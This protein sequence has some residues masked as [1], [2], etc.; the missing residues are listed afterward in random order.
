LGLVVF[1]CGA[2]TMV[3]EL[4]GS[5]LL[6]PYMGTSIYVWTGL[7]GIILGCLSLGYWWGGK[8][9]DARPDAGFFSL[10]I[11]LAALFVGALAF[12]NEF[13][14]IAIQLT[15]NDLRLAAVAASLALF[16]V[17]SVLL[18]MAV[19]YAVRLKMTSVNQSGSTVGG[20]YA[21]STI[22]SIAGTFLAGFFLIAY[23]NQNLILFLVAVTLALA[24]AAIGAQRLLKLKIVV[25]AFFMLCAVA[26]NSFAAHMNSEL[27][28]LNT[29]YNRVRIYRGYIDQ[30]AVPVKIMQVNDETD[31]MMR[32]DSDD[33]AAE[34]TKYYRLVQHF[35][36]GF[37][38]TLMIGGAAYSYPKHY[39]REFPEAS[40]DVVE[41]DPGL[42]ELARKHF[43]LKDDPRLRIIHE[44]A[45]TFLNR[46]E[47][48]YD[49][50]FCD[51]FKSYSIP[52]QL[53]TKEAAQKMY[54]LLSANGVVI[55]NVISSVEGDAGM[56]LRAEVATMKS[57]FPKVLLYPV[58]D[59]DDPHLVQN[60]ML[61]ALKSSGKVPYVNADAELDKFLHHLWINDL[62]DDMPVITDD[63]APV[64]RYTMSVLPELGNRNR[65]VDFLNWQLQR[66]LTQM[67]RWLRIEKKLS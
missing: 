45:R 34:Y 46:G 20:L 35:N 28:D 48:R 42:T 4:L 1:I 11:F 66:M 8:M 38:K 6:A 36:P 29:R 37:K 60:I 39:L 57:V 10:L 52:H 55:M 14:L 54:G 58:K 16:G 22:G 7:I 47:G 62:T 17:P 13:I 65:N 5:R 12:L 56:F 51:A 25:A 2:C 44:D 9:A 67:K 3:L 27:I 59:P 24:S 15:F 32:L 43:G 50:I 18:G 63:F 26:A 61:V 23:F 31:S 53:A 21:L 49:A 30:G 41:I 64:E 33:L 19:P 40:I